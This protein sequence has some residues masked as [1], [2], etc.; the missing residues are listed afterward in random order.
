MRR[1]AEA[2]AGDSEGPGN[3]KIMM[4]MILLRA[5][6]NSPSLFLILLRGNAMKVQEERSYTED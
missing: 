2:L 1:V 6:V 3:G 5:I 4:M